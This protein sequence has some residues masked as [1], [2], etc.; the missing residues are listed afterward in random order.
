M[1]RP[2][3]AIKNLFIRQ[4]KTLAVAESCTGGLLAN[5]LTN[6]PGSSQYFLLGLVAYSNQ[7]KKSLLSVCDKVIK[8]HGAVSYQAARLMAKNVRKIASSDYGIGITGI[9]GPG[10]GTQKKPVGTVFISVAGRDRV[11]SNKCRFSGNRLE[12]KRKAALK[13]ISMLKRL[14][15]VSCEL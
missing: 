13:A 1:S 5:L 8:E 12:I 6:I 14:L 9:A 10:G 2:E 4:K 3:I 15:T 7:V 11:I